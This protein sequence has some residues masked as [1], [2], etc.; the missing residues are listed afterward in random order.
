MTCEMASIDCVMKNIWLV[1]A[2]MLVSYF[3]NI[4]YICRI[5]YYL[6]LYNMKNNIMLYLL[7]IID[8]RS[9]VI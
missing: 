8:Y 2:F 5:I 7:C 1:C 6:M 4:L 9:Y 3:Q